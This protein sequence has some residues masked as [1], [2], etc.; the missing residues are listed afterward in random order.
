MNFKLDYVSRIL[1]K[2]SKKRIENY[3]ISR[4]WHQLNNDEIKISHQQYVNRDNDIYALT[5]LY[6]PQ[7]NFHIEVN[8]EFHYKDENKINADKVREEDIRRKTG[9]TVRYIECQND[10]KLE[11]IHLQIDQIVDEIN[12]LVDEQ[13]KLKTFHPW[14]EEELKP[15]YWKEKGIV[16]VS[17]NINLRTIDDIGLLF[18]VEIKNRGFLKAG[19]VKYTK[20]GFSEVWW[21]SSEIKKSNWENKFENDFEK[22][23]EKNLTENKGNSHVQHYINNNP[24]CKRIVFFKYKDELGFNFYKFV[25]CFKLN[26]EKSTD[27]NQ[28]VWERF[29]SHHKLNN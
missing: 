14:D 5:D 7:L 19:A 11:D 10:K 2:T 4:I 9:H 21:P 12:N 6:F 25:G 24:E 28:L 16:N 22:I 27:E 13:K 20:D 29:S 15:S 8:E 1:Q 26:S 17:D 23:T 3:V 18:N